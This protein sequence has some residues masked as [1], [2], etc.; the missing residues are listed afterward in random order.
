MDLELQGKVFLVTA[1]TSGFGLATAGMLL[2]EGACVVISSPTRHS[3]DQV[4]ARL[5]QDDRTVGIAADSTDPAAADRLITAALTHFG[6]LDGGLLSIGEPP[7]GTLTAVSDR[8]WHSAFESGFPSTVRL[9]RAAA[10][11][12]PTAGAIGLV[13]PLP[14]GQRSVSV[15]SRLR[16]GLATVVEMLAEEL[17][18]QGI[19]VNGLIAG[20]CGTSD[21]FARAATFVLSPAATYLT[22]NVITIDGE[23][24]TGHLAGVF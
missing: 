14:P 11:V 24:R 10:P 3:V 8:R 17:E 21:G 15:L 1:A 18:P 9:A 12:L 2:A 22:G 20:R 13:G 6:R 16:S 23:D 7:A 4:A 19:R 5:G